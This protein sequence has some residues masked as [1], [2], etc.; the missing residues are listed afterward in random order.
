MRDVELRVAA[1]AE[2]QRLGLLHLPF[3]H[4]VA[5]QDELGA[6]ESGVGWLSDQG[7]E[8]LDVGE[9]VLGLL[10]GGDVTVA[11]PDEDGDPVAVE[12]GQGVLQADSE[13]ADDLV[14]MG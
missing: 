13:L 6:G 1:V 4:R 8:R 11:A 2:E 12:R 7:V 10:P 9:A 3:A 5:V 14:R